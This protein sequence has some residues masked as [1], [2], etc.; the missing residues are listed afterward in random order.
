[1]PEI[2]K[3][4]LEFPLGFGIV[5]D[6]A[7]SA[8]VKAYFT[9]HELKQILEFFLIDDPVLPGQYFP[10]VSG[11]RFAY[12]SSKPEFDMVKKI[13][14][15]DLQS[16]YKSIDISASSQELYSL[17][18]PLYAGLLLVAVP[19]LTKGALEFTPK[20]KDGTPI[21]IRTE[22]LVDPRTSTSPYVLSDHASIE[23]SVAITDS[24]Q[25]EIKEWQAIMDYMVQLP[26]KNS[27]SLSVLHMNDRAKEIRA[28]RV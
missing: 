22:A 25:H 13:E 10:R 2:S 3:L 9:G 21:K 28:L 16:G 11:M 24:P 20:K 8:M 17:A 19:K 23:G 26:D 12:D 7:G 27:E 18:C 6:T 5:D 4:S 1:M 14:M 15:G